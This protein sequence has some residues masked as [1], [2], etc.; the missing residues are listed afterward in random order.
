MW[1]ASPDKPYPR[2]SPRISA[3]R[4]RA[5]SSSSITK[6]PAPEVKQVQDIQRCNDYLT[7]GTSFEGKEIIQ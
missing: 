5:C 4:E 6:I 7:I 2:I 1:L 3:P